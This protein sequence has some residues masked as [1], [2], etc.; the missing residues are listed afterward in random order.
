MNPPGKWG[1]WRFLVI[2]GLLKPER[3]SP[4]WENEENI[5]VLLLYSKD[6]EIRGKCSSVNKCWRSASSGDLA[7]W[8]C[9]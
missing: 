4:E 1:R 3:C 6:L 5:C 7:C 8:H 9:A 2:K